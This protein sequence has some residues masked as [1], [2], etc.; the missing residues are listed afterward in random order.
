M[1]LLRRYQLPPDQNDSDP[2][3]TFRAQP[4]PKT[5]NQLIN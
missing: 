2:S 1:P 3:K 4:Q 5:S